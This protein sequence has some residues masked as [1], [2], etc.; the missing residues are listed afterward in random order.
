MLVSTD[1]TAFPC[2]F[3]K[4]LGNINEDTPES[5]WN[6]QKAQ[7]LR[8]FIKRDQIHPICKG[9]VCKYV[10][11]SL[12]ARLMAR[13]DSD[14]SDALVELLKNGADFYFALAS[15]STERGNVF[16]A[17]K[18]ETVTIDQ[19]GGGFVLSLAGGD[20]KA[21]SSARTE[22]FS[23]RVPGVF[24]RQVSGRKVRVRAL[25]R[26]ATGAATRMAVAY[27]TNEVGNS[28]WRWHDIGPVWSICEIEWSVPKMKN[29]DGDYIGLL[30]DEPGTEGVQIHSVSATIVRGPTI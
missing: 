10:Q 29:G 11:N 5:I 25:A 1:G 19:T 23:I 13:A 27:S 12:A 20:P 16:N 28:G 9:A 18:I 14:A 30:P 17:P 2:C 3:G 6:G 7:E 21:E 4:Q 15:S 24:E 8:A 26:S 22:G